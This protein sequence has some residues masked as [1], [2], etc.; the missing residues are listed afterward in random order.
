MSYSFDFFVFG[1]DANHDRVVDTADLDALSMNWNRSGMQFRQGD[2][3]YDGNV[4]VG[5][6]KILSANWQKSLPAPGPIPDAPTSLNA[7]LNGTQ[8]ELTWL[9]QSTNETGFT[10]ERKTGAAGTWAQLD[11][12]GANVQSYSDTTAVAGN[13]YYYRVFA[14]N[15]G[16]NSENSNEASVA[17]PMPIVT[18]YLSDLT[19][20]AMTNGWGPVEKDKSN[21]E[22]ASGDGRTITLAGVPYNKG[23][24]VHANSSIT[25]A[26]NGNY[27]TFL[28][29]IG[30]DDEV[31]NAGSVIFQ[32]YL[33]NVL[34][35]TS[36]TLTG[37]SATQQ[38][39]LN[40]TGKTTLR[41]VVTDAGNG[42]TSDHA[43]WANA[44]LLS[45]GS[46]SNLAPTPVVSPPPSSSAARR[47]ASRRIIAVVP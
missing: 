6:L 12:V 34:S 18:T 27:T 43:D 21:G 42:A 40:V 9:D 45:G 29:D 15:T 2:F 37:S 19:W 26:L 46:V 47:T 31:G 32:V 36:S 7:T 11:Q 24:G 13:T 4:D 25:Y 16:G 5:D 39:N 35:F 44:R 33:D 30:V 1:G 3:N 17:Y 41:L 28:A 10:I 22:Q 14:Y 8:I 38:V 20:T 23:L